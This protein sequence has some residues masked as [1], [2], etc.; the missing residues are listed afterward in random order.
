MP[1]FGYKFEMKDKYEKN[2]RVSSTNNNAESSQIGVKIK[3]I[4]E[5]RSIFYYFD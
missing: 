3:Q 2:F 5:L 4:S 1:I